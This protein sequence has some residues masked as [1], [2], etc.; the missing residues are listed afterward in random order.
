MAVLSID[1]QYEFGEKI[2]TIVMFI[3]LLTEDELD[4]LKSLRDNLKKE[5]STLGAVAGIITPLEESEHKMARHNAM[6]KRIDALI[7]IHESNFEMGDADSTLAEAKAGRDKI[8]SMF[9]LGGL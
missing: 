2:K 6:V 5:N 7:A 4:T 1:D 9:G 3:G 8:N